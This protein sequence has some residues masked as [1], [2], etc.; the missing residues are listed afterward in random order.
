MNV[1]DTSNIILAS[2]AFYKEDLYKKNT[3]FRFQEETC[4]SSLLGYQRTFF[5]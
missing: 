1:T 2:P 3:A 4:F 5:G